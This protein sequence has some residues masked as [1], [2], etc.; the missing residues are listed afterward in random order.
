MWGLIGLSVLAAV[1]SDI[2]EPFLKFLLAI[3]GVLAMAR[4]LA[5]LQKH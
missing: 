4:I 1:W 2:F 3:I 5:S